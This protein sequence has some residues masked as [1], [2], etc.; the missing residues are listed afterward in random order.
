[1]SYCSVVA[2]L[3]L[4]AVLA[5]TKKR[6]GHCSILKIYPSDH[7]VSAMTTQ[8][9]VENKAI[10]IIHYQLWLSKLEIFLN[11]VKIALQ[12]QENVV[13]VTVLLGRLSCHEQKIL[14]DNFYNRNSQ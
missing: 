7:Q 12:S 6:F 1:M 14:A 5:L 3:A 9:R 8:F 4:A 11:S 10:N 13:Y 2:V